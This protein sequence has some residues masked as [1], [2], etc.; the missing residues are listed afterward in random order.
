MLDLVPPEAEEE[1]ACGGTGSLT[2]ADEDSSSCAAV[3]AAAP[4]TESVA[5]GAMDWARS[6]M[7]ERSPII[8]LVLIPASSWIVISCLP[9]SKSSPATVAWKELSRCASTRS[10]KWWRRSTVSTKRRSRSREAVHGELPPRALRL[11]LEWREIHK[12][13]LLENWELAREGRP[14]KRIAPLE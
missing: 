12:V 14:L 13:E 6:S 1:A 10:T 3:G 5:G 4:A 9:I 2:E 8:C 11:V 7:D